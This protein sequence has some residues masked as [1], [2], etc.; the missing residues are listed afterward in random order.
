VTGLMTAFALGMLVGCE[1]M[2]W[3]VDHSDRRA[4]RL[5]DRSDGAGG[6]PSAGPADVLPLPVRPRV[7]PRVADWEWFSDHERSRP[8]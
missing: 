8:D 4:E 7:V 2:D 1:L 5:Q 6:T 3:L